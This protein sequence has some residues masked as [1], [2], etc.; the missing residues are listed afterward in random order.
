MLN[1]SEIKK[2]NLSPGQIAAAAL[3]DDLY[4]SRRNKI[5][6]LLE[7][8]GQKYTGDIAT[9][10][11]QV[12][13]LSGQPA[14]GTVG[15]GRFFTEDFEDIAKEAKYFD[16]SEALNV[17]SNVAP[18][19]NSILSNIHVGGGSSSSSSSGGGSSP[20]PA[21][22]PPVPV[23]PASLIAD[24][25]NLDGYWTETDWNPNLN[26]YVPTR[27]I[28]NTILD[29]PYPPSD[30]SP[31]TIIPDGA[32]NKIYSPYFKNHGTISPDGKTIYWADNNSRWVKLANLAGVVS[33]SQ[34]QP[35]LQ[36]IY[37][38]NQNGTPVD[39]RPGAQ[40]L[41]Q[42]VTTAATTAPTKT[43]LGMKPV[44]FYVSLAGII[45]AAIIVT[46]LIIR[47]N[48]KKKEASK[49]VS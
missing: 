29:Y 46:F 27:I 1:A 41:A 7:N 3:F 30:G 15:R 17:L 9:D 8:H 23:S 20:A 5:K 31:I 11:M 37:G 6:T 4:H 32:P 14:S 26:S 16:V 47:N 12:A 43:I 10:L 2:L 44:Y 19:A 21:T 28:N 48:K 40:Q 24:P 34:I 18:L 22:P 49:K 39:N 35:V 36:Q 42:M 13:A 33:T 25:N 38:P 45:V